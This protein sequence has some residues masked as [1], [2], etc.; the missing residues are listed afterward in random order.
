MDAQRQQQSGSGTLTALSE[1]P[2]CERH[3]LRHLRH[4]LLDPHLP[5]GDRK[6]PGVPCCL[7]ETRYEDGKE[8]LHRQPGR[9]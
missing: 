3:S 6:R 2:R 5:R 7:A 9:V 8:S 1:K 4:A